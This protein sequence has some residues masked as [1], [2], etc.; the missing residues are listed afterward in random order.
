MVEP[1]SLW[2]RSPH[3]DAD[4]KA[5]AFVAAPIG[6]L[7]WGLAAFGL[8]IGYHFLLAKFKG[9]RFDAFD[10]PPSETVGSFA[11]RE[12]PQSGNLKRDA[13]TEQPDKQAAIASEPSY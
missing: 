5:G 10:R 13:G 1:L 12:T 6:G 2:T 11:A 7:L 8:R 4:L 9:R 3:V